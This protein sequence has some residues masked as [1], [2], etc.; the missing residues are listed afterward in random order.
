MDRID[1]EQLVRIVEGPLDSL[2]LPNCVASGDANL[3]I[4]AKTVDAKDMVLIFDNEPRNK[5]IVKMVAT[6]IEK[7]YSVVI[8]PENIRGKDIN[9]MVIHGL[10][11]KDIGKVIEESTVSGLTATIKLNQWKKV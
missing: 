11:T 8:W 9:E 3:A 6:A 10:T 2:F 1:K 5:D 7:G 4:A